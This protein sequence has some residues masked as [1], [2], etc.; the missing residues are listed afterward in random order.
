MMDYIRNLL[1]LIFAISFMYILLDCALKSKKQLYLLGLYAAAVVLCNVFV[2]RNFGYT[3]FMR[4]Y[5]LLIQTTVFLCFVFL[6]KFSVIKVFFVHLTAVAITTSFVLI[7]LV[8]S[9]LL[10][11]DRMTV[12]VVC[13]I[14]Y[15]P[16]WFVFYRYLR[17]SFLYMLRNTDKGW[18]GFC[19]IPFVYSVLVYFTGKYDLNEVMFLSSVQDAILTFI[20]TLAAYFLIFRSFKQTRE[21]LTMQNEQNLLRTQVAAAQV[22]LEALKESQEKTIIYRHD[23]R[24]HLSLINAYLADNN[25]AAAQEYI[26]EVENAIRG[27]TVEKYCSNYTVNLILYSYISKAKNDQIAVETQIDLPERNAIS[28]MDLC[29]IFANAIENAVNACNHIRNVEDRTLKIV[30]TPKNDRLFVQITNSYEGTVKLVNDMPVS[31]EENHGIG[32]KSITA[33]AQKYGGMCSF[34]AEHGVF[35]TSIIL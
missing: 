19:T 2:L 1:S 35:K 4:L 3:T 6:S 5:P 24:H 33:V 15:L 12:N 27:A 10:G 26:I 9:H 32:T 16:T 11:S 20:L 18:F 29:V 34:T 17:P 7:G 13:Y 21:Q 31:T 28:D 25:E 14:I 30:C 23:M 22:H 8:I